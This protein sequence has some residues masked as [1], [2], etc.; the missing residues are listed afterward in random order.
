MAKR[1]DSSR[2][3]RVPLTPIATAR[4]PAPPPASAASS[5]LSRAEVAF[6]LL[7]VLCTFLSNVGPVATN[8]IGFHLR[9]G[10]EIAHHGPPTV[11]THSYT[12]P[13]APYPDHEWLAQL[14]LW[15]LYSA[16]GI[17]GLAVCQGALVAATVALLLRFTPGPAAARGFVVLPVFF[18][19]F[20]HSEIRPHLLGWLYLASLGGLLSKRRYPAVLALLVLWANSHASVLLG[21]GLAGLVV[22]EDA[23]RARSAARLGWAAAIALVPLLNPYGAEVYTLF[24]T[25]TESAGFVGEWRPYPSD[26]WQFG[27]QVA[28]VLAAAWGIVRNGIN[29]FDIVRLLVLG[30]LSFEASRSGVVMAIALAPDLGRWFA[31][32][33]ARLGRR[34][35]SLGLVATLAAV[36]AAVA[37]RARDGSA[38]RLDVDRERLPVAAVEFIQ[39]HRLTGHMFNDYNF[40]GY[41]LWMAPEHPVFMDGRIEVYAGK[42]LDE[43][44]AVSRAAPNWEAIVA[45]Y[46][47]SF[48][49]VR[50]ERGIATELVDNP[51]WKLV[52]FDYNAVIF[53][54]A[55]RFS[56]LRAL[57][58]ITPFGNRP[59]APLGSAAE[60]MRYLLVENPS[61]FGGHKVLAFLMYKAGDVPAAAAAL[62]E[63]LR[64]HPEGEE[65]D[66]TQEL[67]RALRQRG[68]WVE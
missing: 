61:F 10:E 4:T 5:G 41:F 29:P 56:D 2:N 7:L 52:Y 23:W 28:I 33:F 20:D 21:V 68:A 12:A 1:R 40:G 35:R 24:F 13:G 36:S 11:D 15:L 25:I 9:L 39:R 44:L 58:T 26:S 60:E 30:T 66:E 55:D 67:V 31:P 49:V 27:L 65:L 22:L 59:G 3:P 46:D 6:L 38:M 64:L 43:H 17:P 62:R 51:Q 18:L 47:V 37:V 63:Y 50:P 19:A 14:G 16:L 57:R 54:R 48:F 34:A 8:D 32:G 45:A 53:V 42:V